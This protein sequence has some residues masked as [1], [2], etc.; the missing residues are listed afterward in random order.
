MRQR[1]D[2]RGFHGGFQADAIRQDVP[3]I[4]VRDENLA[5]SADAL[6]RGQEP[7][8][9]GPTPLCA[10]EYTNSQAQERAALSRST[11]AS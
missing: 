5:Q 3:D 9:T 1:I 8:A 2:D 10:K 7:F 11:A 6:V 4:G